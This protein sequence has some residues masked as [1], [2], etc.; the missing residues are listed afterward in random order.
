MIEADVIEGAQAASLIERF[1]ANSDVA[2]LH[3]HTA[4]RGCFLAT[5]SRA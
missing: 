1:L 2:Y 3:A 5:I 4:R